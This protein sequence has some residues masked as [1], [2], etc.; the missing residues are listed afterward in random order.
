MAWP[1]SIMTVKSDQ[2]YGWFLIFKIQ[3][4]QRGFF[5]RVGGCSPEFSGDCTAGTQPPLGEC[6]GVSYAFS[7]WSKETEYVVYDNH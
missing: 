1:P 2:K 4:T 7:L 5:S 3:E 6:L